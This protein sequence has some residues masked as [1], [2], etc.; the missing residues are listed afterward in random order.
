MYN[1]LTSYTCAP[2]I[3]IQKQKGMGGRPATRAHQLSRRGMLRNKMIRRRQ[4]GEKQQKMTPEE[5]RTATTTR[6]LH[7]NSAEDKEEGK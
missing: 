6:Q 7:R 2:K 5:T 4:E 1:L 3:R